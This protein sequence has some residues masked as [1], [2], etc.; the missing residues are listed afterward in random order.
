M[1]AAYLGKREYA[2]S[3]RE[4]KEDDFI[5]DDTG[6]E[7]HVF[8]FDGRFWLSSNDYDDRLLEEA[9]LSEAEIVVI[10]GDP[11]TFSGL[12]EFVLSELTKIERGSIDR[13]TKENIWDL[14]KRLKAL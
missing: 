14:E 10:S 7:Y 9:D 6:T 11:M 5:K 12:K 13:F 4:I 3:D 1:V 2:S 8:Q